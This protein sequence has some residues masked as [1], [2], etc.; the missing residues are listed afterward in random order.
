MYICMYVCMY[1]CILQIR[2]YIMC[3]CKYIAV[4]LMS[5]CFYV[6]SPLDVSLTQENIKMSHEH[7]LP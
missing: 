2:V 5:M 3:V 6:I 7:Q 4:A 1:V